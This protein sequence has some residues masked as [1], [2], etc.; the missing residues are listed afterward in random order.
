MSKVAW[1]AP[2][3]SADFS[4]LVVCL[5]GRED[6][7]RN[8]AEMQRILPRVQVVEAVDGHRLTKI[9][10]QVL[11]TDGLLPET[12]RLCDNYVH[13]PD[14]GR[15]LKV[16]EVGA[17]LSHRKALQVI[18][19]GDAPGG[20]I[21]EDDVRP[22]ARFCEKLELALGF[23]NDDTDLIHLFIFPQQKK[24]FPH[25][26]AYLY[27][28]PNGLFGLQCYFV[29]KAGAKFALERLKPMLGA[30][31]E[32]ATRVGLRSYVVSGIEFVSNLGLCGYSDRDKEH[33]GSHA[34]VRRYV[35]DVLEAPLGAVGEVPKTMPLPGTR[36]PPTSPRDSP[37]QVPAE[38][39]AL[40][41]ALPP[42]LPPRAPAPAALP[43]SE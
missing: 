18:A 33:A 38:A 10:F 20:V 34:Q 26:G 32:M 6:R 8:V 5:T 31:D 42:A 16:G 11:Q 43:P 28:A 29:T 35:K 39:L 40:E 14:R 23:A 22:C 12:S 21:F 24:Q 27:K 15:P 37:E 17:F 9:D 19:D 30:V 3:A 41:Q 1:K 36:A 2:G 7:R 13:P 4:F 25:K